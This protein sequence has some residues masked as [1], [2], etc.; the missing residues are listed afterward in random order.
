MM[1]KILL[2]LTAV[3]AVAGWVVAFLSMSESR[4]L[5]D[6]MAAAKIELTKASEQLTDTQ[7]RLALMQGAASS[8]DDIHKPVAAKQT[9]AAA[10]DEEIGAKKRE[11]GTLRQDLDS[12]KTELGAMAD[13]ISASKSELSRLTRDQELA[14]AK[15]DWQRAKIERQ[16][17]A[18]IDTPTEKQTAA[19]APRVPTDA[20]VAPVAMNTTTAAAISTADPLADAK[21]RFA[22]IDQDGD[23]R[24]DRLDFRLKRVSL[25]G[26]V[27]ANEDGY[28]TLD[29]TLLSPEAFQ[30]FDSDGDGKISSLE[31]A[32]RRG[33]SVM[34][35]NR[36][37]FV[38]FEE[39]AIFLHI[40]P[41]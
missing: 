16:R 1:Q 27:D 10:L 29:E 32:D 30:R 9:E 15:L 13:R 21:R 31:S 24:F 35:T 28:L 19:Q 4:D 25:F 8:L 12:G 37:D 3:A 26:M 17:A 40:S 36:D 18:A 5:E 22:R 6:Q 38:S 39:Y 41:E 14:E 2:G 7:G 33:F 34:D 11:L 23:G 20:A